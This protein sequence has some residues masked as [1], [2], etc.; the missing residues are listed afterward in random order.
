MLDVGTG[1][2]AIA[3]AFADEHPGARVT[4]IDVSADA[5]ALAR[6]NAARTGLAIEL[7]EHDL[8]AGLPDGP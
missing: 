7:L 6:E 4:A 8:R 2:G 5:L 3:L 1:T